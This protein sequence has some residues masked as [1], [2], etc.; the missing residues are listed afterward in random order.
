MNGHYHYYYI[1]IVPL[2]AVFVVGCRSSLDH[3]YFELF[4]AAWL[5]SVTVTVAAIFLFLC[6]LLG[7]GS[8]VVSS[9]EWAKSTSANLIL[10][11]SFSLISSITVAPVCSTTEINIYLFTYFC[12]LIINLDLE[13]SHRYHNMIIHKQYIYI[14]LYNIPN[15]NYYILYFSSI[16]S[17]YLLF[18]IVASRFTR[19]WLITI[20]QT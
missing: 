4:A 11:R 17:L 13:D 10:E 1:D 3:V 8:G 14:L 2:H 6:S 19:A 15:T 12:F 5:W 9:R 18:L 20:S 7:T 16:W